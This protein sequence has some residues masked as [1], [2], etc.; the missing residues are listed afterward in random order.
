[1]TPI[2]FADLRHRLTLEQP[3]SSP[4]GAGG[5]TITWSAL[6]VLWARIE[7]KTGRETFTHDQMETV[8]SHEITARYDAAIRPNMRLLKNSR[9]FEILA[10][11]NLEEKSR[12]QQILVREE[13]L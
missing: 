3:V 2:R 10:V 1:M 9:I 13:D 12:W 11:I 6:K 8:I 4:D 7:P 5:V